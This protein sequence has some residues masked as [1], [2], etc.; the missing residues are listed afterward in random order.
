MQ[1][2]DV[3]ETD[4]RDERHRRM[5]LRGKA[6]TDGLSV[7]MSFYLGD[8]RLC[9]SFWPSQSRRRTSPE[10]DWA[11]TDDPETDVPDTEE[12]RDGCPETE[13]VLLLLCLKIVEARLKWVLLSD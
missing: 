4:G 5:P 3:P 8:I 13:G 2:R 9:H 12:G 7:L 10:T 1:E 6:K 11:E